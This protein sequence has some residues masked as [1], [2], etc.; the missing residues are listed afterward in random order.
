[1][2]TFETLILSPTLPAKNTVIWLHGLGADG[3]DFVNIVPE[4]HLPEALAVRF[5]FPHAPV[6]PVSLNNGLPMRAWFDIHGLTGDAKIDERGIYESDQA[7]RVLI[8]QEIEQGI[9]CENIILV[10]FSQGG[11]LALYS[12]L[13]YPKRLGGILGL[14]T[15]LPINALRQTQTQQPKDVPIFMAHG[16]YDTVVLPGL[17]HASREYLVTQGYQA[18]WRTYPM[19]HSV[20]APEIHDISTWL[21]KTLT[22][23]SP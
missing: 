10:G 4:L 11:A 12:G 13:I 23:S 16:D 8:R 7:L 15:Y 22:P 19:A 5:I 2:K 17:G 21:I 6:R 3:H 1:M 18:E 20:C 14:S 9:P